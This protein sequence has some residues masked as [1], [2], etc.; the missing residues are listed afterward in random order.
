[1][2]RYFDDYQGVRFYATKDRK[3]IG[4]EPCGSDEQNAYKLQTGSAGSKGMV[5]ASSF[6]EH[7]GLEF[8]KTKE[9]PAEWSE[10]E[11]VLLVDISNDNKE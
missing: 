3:K 2:E 11:G 7:I 1:M 8:E 6:L 5:S 10:A 9:I 4:L